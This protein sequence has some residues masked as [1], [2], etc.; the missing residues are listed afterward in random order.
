MLFALVRVA[1]S[2]DTVLMVPSIRTV[3]VE[4]LAEGAKAWRCPGRILGVAIDP[5]MAFRSLSDL[6]TPQDE[7][8]LSGLNNMSGVDMVDSCWLDAGWHLPHF[9]RR[10]DFSTKLFGVK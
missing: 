7:F 3:E 4:G 6:Y 1:W 9:T 8:A 2:P 10:R 5:M